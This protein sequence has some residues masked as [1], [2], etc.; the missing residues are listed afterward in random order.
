MT[1]IDQ[2]ENCYND[3]WS[4]SIFPEAFSHPG[5]FSR[6]LIHRIYRHA[7][8]M[9]WVK[10]GDWVLD[11]FGGVALGGLDAMSMNLNWIGIELEQKF[12]DLGS[13]NIELWQRQL[14]G[15]PN[16]GTARIVQGDSRRLR[17]CIEGIQSIVTGYQTHKN[18]A[19]M[20]ERPG[21]S[22]NNKADIVISS[23]PYSD[24][25]SR[26]RA[27]ENYAQSKNDYK[28]GG[29]SQYEIYGHSPGNLANF[30]EGKF[31]MV[32]GSEQ[33]A[34]SFGLLYL[35]LPNAFN[36]KALIVELLVSDFISFNLGGNGVPIISIDFNDGMRIREIEI[37]SHSPNL[38]LMDIPYVGFPEKLDEIS[39]DLALPHCPVT[40]DRTIFATTIVEAMRLY[41]KNFGAHRA[42]LFDAGSFHSN[43]A[44]NGAIGLET[45]GHLSL[46]S[47]N[48]LSACS[49]LPNNFGEGEIM[50]TFHR[51]KF[52]STPFYIRLMSQENLIAIR[53][54][55][56]N[57]PNPKKISANLRAGTIETFK[58]LTRFCMK[59]FSTDYTYPV[60]L[61]PI[62]PFILA[63]HNIN[64]TIFP[65]IMSRD[66]FGSID[67]VISSPPYEGHIGG[68]EGC[69]EKNN[70]F[71]ARNTPGGRIG[72]SANFDYGKSKDNLGNSS[73]DTFWSASRE[74]VQQCFD[75]LKLNGHAIWVCKD[76]CK[77]GKR[78]PFSK[79][80]VTLCES[81]GFRLIHWHKAMLVKPEGEQN[82]IRGT[83]YLEM[84]RKSFFRRNHET[85][86]KAAKFWPILDVNIQNEFLTIAKKQVTV[87]P[88][89]K[90]ILQKAQVLAFKSECLDDRPYK[91]EIMI[92]HEDIIC[93]VK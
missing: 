50:E 27:S 47:S 90:K 40:P 4:G 53:T 44:S 19:D 16:L 71:K 61:C 17:E 5:K 43:K 20:S 65:P 48:F 59:G 2:W 62:S 81:V 80:W 11:P 51:T 1:S 31:E 37:T 78:I 8:E 74:I 85:K 70:W 54:L 88:T 58:D 77:G 92:D 67:A 22:L 82:T 36:S 68:G 15:W 84:E 18:L 41:G 66:K 24:E 75:L 91:N 64:S 28:R 89:E 14:K 35:V 9:R 76:Y 34:E 30:K 29:K 87:K 56:L 79:R 33:V 42:C 49:A 93:L 25:V 7:K 13:L 3:N 45:P 32:V 6:G 57:L 10:P 46:S 72:I 23:P 38:K 21:H 83:Q 73:G 39:F 52:A 63:D 86:I 60:R 12:V 69:A 26:D 55:P